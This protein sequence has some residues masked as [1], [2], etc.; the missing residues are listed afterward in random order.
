MHDMQDHV[1]IYGDP[2]FLYEVLKVRPNLRVM[3]EA[4]SPDICGFHDRGMHVKVI[5]FDANDF[6]D[7]V[8]D[9][10]EQAHAQ[11]FVDRLGNAD[12]PAAWQEAFDDDVNGIQT[13]LPA[14]LAGYLRG[15]VLATHCST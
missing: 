13:N 14:E 12:K 2:F 7:A 8:I 9:V 4:D 10:A 11:I 1:V 15:H 6:K 5:A 3:P